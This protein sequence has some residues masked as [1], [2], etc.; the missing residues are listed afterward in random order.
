M[1]YIL[2]LEKQEIACYIVCCLPFLG[3]FSSLQ[4]KAYS[5][6]I[7]IKIDSKMQISTA[8]ALKIV[9]FVQFYHK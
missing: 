7:K 3:I 6:N 8:S 4:Q 9:K 5:K 2:L 1:L